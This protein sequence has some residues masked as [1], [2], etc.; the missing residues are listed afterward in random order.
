[1]KDRF[2]KIAHSRTFLSKSYFAS[3][4]PLPGYR[5]RYPPGTPHPRPHSPS[6]LIRVRHPTIT[7][8]SWKVKKATY[9]LET[10]TYMLVAT[11]NA[12]VSL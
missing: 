10:Y 2:I 3:H 9:E 1:M 7:Y 12:N 8:N 4:L 5:T 11:S 6:L